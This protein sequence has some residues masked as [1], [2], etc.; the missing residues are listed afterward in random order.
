M[1]GTEGR[2]LWASTGRE[3]CYWGSFIWAQTGTRHWVEGDFLPY[4]LIISSPP[5]PKRTQK[6]LQLKPNPMMCFTCFDVTS[7]WLVLCCSITAQEKQKIGSWVL[8]EKSRPFP[9]CFFSCRFFSCSQHLFLFFPSA[10][11]KKR[12]PLWKFCLWGKFLPSSVCS[13]INQRETGWKEGVFPY[14]QVCIVFIRANPLF[15][16]TEWV[17]LTAKGR[18]LICLLEGIA[19]AIGKFGVCAVQKNSSS[20]FH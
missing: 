19:E 14:K 1:S 16:P 20:L 5:Y 8:K 3:R 13:F 7:C 6:P 9:K 2:D 11:W 17:S 15:S 12:I 18:L 4:P 10:C